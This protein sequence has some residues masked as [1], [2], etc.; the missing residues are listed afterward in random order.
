MDARANRSEQ[1]VEYQL[2]GHGN[3][4]LQLDRTIRLKQGSTA[5]LLPQSTFAW[6]LC[7]LKQRCSFR[8]EPAPQTSTITHDRDTMPGPRVSLSPG[9]DDNWRAATPEMPG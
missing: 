5:R 9:V 4:V 6:P 2:R 7:D 1:D 8:A 3:R